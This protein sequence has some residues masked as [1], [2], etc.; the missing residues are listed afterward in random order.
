[1]QIAKQAVAIFS[2]ISGNENNKEIL[3][4]YVYDFFA[5][6][7][8]KTSQIFVAGFDTYRLYLNKIPNCLLYENI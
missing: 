8:T 2:L 6:S 4:I 5:S 1:M 3:C 7:I